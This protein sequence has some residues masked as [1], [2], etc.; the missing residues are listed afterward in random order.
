MSKKINISQ[1]LPKIN[2]KDMEMEEELTI[3]I[4]HA[5]LLNKIIDPRSSP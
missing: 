2:W 5:N 3:I 1:P 4:P